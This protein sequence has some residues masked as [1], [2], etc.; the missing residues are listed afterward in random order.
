[1]NMF[2]TKG[3]LSGVFIGL[4]T[5]LVFH[6]AVAALQPETERPAAL[7]PSIRELQASADV[8][9][10]ARDAISPA[11][12]TIE[13][14]GGVGAIP[15]VIGGIRRQGE[16]NTTGVVIA[17]DGWIV[18]S[19]FN[20]VQRPPLITVVTS[21]GK[22]HVARLRGQDNTRKICLLKI[23]DVKGLA[24]AEQANPDQLFVGQTALSVGVGYGDTTPSISAGIV[25]ALNRISGRAVQTDAKIS[26]A[27][28]GGPLV[29]VLGRMI[30]VCVP[31]NPQST[32][33]AA[34][35][36]WYDSGIGFAVPLANISDIIERLKNDE[37][38]NPGFL[39]VGV[40]Q[41]PAGEGVLVGEV[42]PESPAAGAGIIAGSIITS[43]NGKETPTPADFRQL[44]SAFAAGGQVT[45]VIRMPGA[46]ATREMQIELGIAP[47][48]KKADRG[49]GL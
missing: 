41:N 26:P 15:G 28:Y 35:V 40:S 36:E 2:R 47:E 30:G 38:I 8:F 33:V 1:M 34:G 48:F 23:D 46:D 21:D 43:V 14:Y 39:G 10:S 29:D 3:F 25:S 9:R 11:L 12:V 6:D 27:C 45:V 17:S 19:T 24:V 22:Q 4:F 13:S 49:P 31:M 5:A 37:T 20:F 16:G 44:I 32:A 18:T 7:A 42:V